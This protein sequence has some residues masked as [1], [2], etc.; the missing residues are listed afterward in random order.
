[1]K[2]LCIINNMNTVNFIIGVRMIGLV[3]ATV[4]I[5]NQDKHPKYIKIRYNLY[6]YL[7]T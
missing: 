2:V 3:T 5:G 1:M 7:S 6:I 4:T